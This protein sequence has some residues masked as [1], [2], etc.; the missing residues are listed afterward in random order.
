MRGGEKVVEAILKLFPA[1]DV[2]TLIHSRG[3]VSKIIEDRVRGTSF[4]QSIPSIE[5]FHRYALPLMPF[6]IRSLDL[7]GYDLVLSS[8]TCVAKAVRPPSGAIHICYCNSPMRYIW[9]QFDAYFGPGRARWPTRLAMS[10]LRRPLQWWDSSSNRGVDLFMANSQNVQKRIKNYYHRESEVVYPPVDI[11]RF[12]LTSTDDGYYLGLSALVSYKRMDTAVRAFRSLDRKLKLA[13]TGPDFDLLRRLAGP[14]VEFLGRVSDEEATHLLERC[15]A[16]VFP[17]EEDFGIVPVE[18][19]ACGKPVIALDRGG[20]KETVVPPDDPKGRWPTGLLYQG[21]KPENLAEA[22][23]RFEEIRPLFIPE[24][25]REHAQL[26]S[27]EIFDREYARRVHLL[28][29]QKGLLKRF[30]ASML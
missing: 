19:M 15:R 1:A 22:I 25:I 2:F 3:S 21:D 16:L 10:L 26:Y 30:P 14:N 17:G 29:Q 13:G 24:K 6:A 28:I 7:R 11:N 18:A 12:H 9:D 8:S 5:R 20:A 23:R 27:P 4:L